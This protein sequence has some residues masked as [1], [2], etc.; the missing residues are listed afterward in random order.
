MIGGN[1]LRKYVGGGKGNLRHGC[2]RRGT[3]ER[4]RILELV[5][6]F[7]QLSQPAGR[8]IAFQGMDGAADNAHDFL[9]AGLFLQLQGFIV[10]RLQQFL[11]SLEE[12]FAQFRAAFVVRFRHSLTSSL[13]YA[14][15]L[16]L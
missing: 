15:P 11:R 1:H 14:V 4:Q 2:L 5:R 3:L 7:A 10:Q 12:E 6:Q 9:V 13:W 16:S 8:R